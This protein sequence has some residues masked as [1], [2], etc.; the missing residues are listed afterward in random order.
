MTIEQH[1]SQDLDLGGYHFKW[2]AAKEYAHN[3]PERFG[4]AESFGWWMEVRKVFLEL[5]GCYVG[6]R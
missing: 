4:E 2:K 5:G 1:V 3:H 6:Q